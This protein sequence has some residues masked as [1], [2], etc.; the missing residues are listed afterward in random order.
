M[1][2]TFG[3]VY[4]GR[5]VLVTGHTG[6]KGGWLG[7]WLRALGAEVCGLALEP[8]ASPNLHSILEKDTY[9]R[10]WTC[11]LRDAPGLRSAIRD[12]RPDV[13][14]HLAAQPLVGVSYREPAATFLTN[15]VG[16]LNLL[17]SLREAACS[18]ATLVVTSDKCYRNDNAGRAFVEE[19]ALG[20]HDVYSMSKA[21]T[22]LVVASWHASFFS[23]DLTLGCLATGRAGNVIGGGDYAE[24]RIVPDMVR[25]FDTARPLI[26]RR[27]QATRPWQHVLES[28]SGYLTLG[29]RM[30]TQPDRTHLLNYNFG[31][32]AEAERTVQELVET[33]QAT[34]PG[35]LQVQLQ[36]E[37][38]YGEALRLTLDHGKAT[39]ELDWKPVWDFEHTVKQ[40]AA[41]YRQRHETH[42]SSESMRELTFQQIAEYTVDARRLGLNWT[43]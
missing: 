39:R 21:A 6:F 18:A 34:W 26:L 5:R 25:A 22:E 10:S 43:H 24:D 36:P 27:P 7:F 19:D 30:L 38:S 31:P 3:G 35:S 14:F 42:A 16:T 2:S 33:W 11:D 13:V 20:G 32:D 28:L 12:C 29:Q 17:E 15:A 8:A 40:T 37:P 41:W 23:K 1:V 9:A 4:S